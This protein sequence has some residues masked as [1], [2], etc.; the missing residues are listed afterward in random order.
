MRGKG[1]DDWP[2]EVPV[3]ELVPT[4]D[5]DEFIMSRR[6]VGSPRGA[7][8]GAVMVATY[9]GMRGRDGLH[10]HLLTGRRRG[11]GA[12]LLY[13]GD[14]DHELGHTLLEIGSP[15]DQIVQFGCLA[16]DHHCV[17]EKV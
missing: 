6:P 15:G 14:C 11:G 7:K 13:I 12:S 16:L 3:C 8:A 2:G 9:R 4:P 5:A 17:R 1:T 10:C